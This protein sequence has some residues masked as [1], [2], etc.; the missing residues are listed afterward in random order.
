MK[1][2]MGNDEFILYI[3]KQHPDCTTPNPTLGRQVWDWLQQA[4]PT[5]QLI[6]RTASYWGD[7]GDFVTATQLPETATQFTFDRA[8]LPELYT[9]LDTLGT[10]RGSE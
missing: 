1:I 3:R 6:G 4:D 2:T 10:G 5:A 8:V 7:T 9:Y